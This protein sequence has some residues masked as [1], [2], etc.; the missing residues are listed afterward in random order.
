MKRKVDWGDEENGGSEVEPFSEASE[1]DVSDD[2]ESND[3]EP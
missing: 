2:V 3:E 1:K